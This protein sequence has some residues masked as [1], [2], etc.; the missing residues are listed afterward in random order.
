METVAHRALEGKQQV[1]LSEL[2]INRLP[3]EIIDTDIIITTS[4]VQR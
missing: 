4:E 3:D 2:D 1:S